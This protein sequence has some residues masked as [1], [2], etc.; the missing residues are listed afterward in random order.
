MLQT[1]WVVWLVIL[2]VCFEKESESAEKFLKP[3]PYISFHVGPKIEKSEFCFPS[4]YPP[5][6]NHCPSDEKLSN[7]YIIFTLLAHINIHTSIKYIKITRRISSWIM[8]IIFFSLFSYAES[9]WSPLNIV[10]SFHPF[11]HS[12]CR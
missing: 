4:H 10:I 7:Y 1:E 2:M 9:L 5:S 8:F 3:V 6:S 11:E 12:H